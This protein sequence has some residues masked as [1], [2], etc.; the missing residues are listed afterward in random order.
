MVCLI[1]RVGWVLA[2]PLMSIQWSPLYK[3]PKANVVMFWLRFV[4]QGQTMAGLWGIRARFESPGGWENMRSAVK[5][6]RDNGETAAWMLGYRGKP[7]LVESARRGLE[8][9]NFGYWRH[10]C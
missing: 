3:K 1:A 5:D 10:D 2:R 6:E 9:S 7:R 8:V 4:Q